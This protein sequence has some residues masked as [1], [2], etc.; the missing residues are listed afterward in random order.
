MDCK[1]VQLSLADLSSVG[2]KRIS[3]GSALSLRCPGAFLRAAKEMKE[4]GTFSFAEETVS[5]RSSARCFDGALASAGWLGASR[6]RGGLQVRVWSL[7]GR[8]RDASAPSR[9]TAAY[10][11]SNKLQHASRS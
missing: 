2:V 3:V 10:Q 6:R 1:G 8:R 9:Y 7:A 5:Y 11:L 4:H